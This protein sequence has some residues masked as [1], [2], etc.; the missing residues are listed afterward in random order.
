MNHQVSLGELSSS[1]IEF[2]LLS[3]NEV[4]TALFI[5]G[6]T[7]AGTHYESRIPGH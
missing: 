3:R 4:T 1:R 2:F 6:Y 7:S 5:D